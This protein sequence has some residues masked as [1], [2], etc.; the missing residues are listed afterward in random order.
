MDQASFVS[1]FMRWMARRLSAR[2][3]FISA[4][5]R[6]CLTAFLLPG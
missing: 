3:R 6:P 1:T 4:V 5:W 2:S